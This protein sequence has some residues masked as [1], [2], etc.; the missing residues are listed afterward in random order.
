MS[1]SM[2]SGRGMDSQTRKRDQ[3]KDG[4]LALA[5]KAMSTSLRDDA[6]PDA[7]CWPSTASA[8]RSPRSPRRLGTLIN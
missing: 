4:F 3:R 7:R 2:K 1:S 6:A 5:R 8:A